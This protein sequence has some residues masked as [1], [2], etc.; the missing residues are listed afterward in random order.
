MLAG[1]AGHSLGGALATLAA[2]DLVKS[3]SVLCPLEVSVYTFGAPRCVWCKEPAL[4]IAVRRAQKQQSK[5]C[6]LARPECASVT[7]HGLLQ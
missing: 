3:C 4:V 7:L 6:V 5:A 2:V 1:A